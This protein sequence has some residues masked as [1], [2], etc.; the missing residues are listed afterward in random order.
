M[1]YPPPPRHAPPPPD[2]V[3][4]PRLLSPKLVAGEG[5]N[6]QTLVVVLVVQLDQL[7]VAE[8]RVGRGWQRGGARRGGGS[9][10]FL[11]GLLCCMQVLPVKGHLVQFVT[12]GPRQKGSFVA[13][14][15]SCMVSMPGWVLVCPMQCSRQMASD[16]AVDGGCG[17]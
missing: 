7:L 5:N 4:W 17:S 16:R 6:L 11:I 9:R 14:L 8:V 15:A 12:R 3:R 1:V 2:L 10:G 13:L